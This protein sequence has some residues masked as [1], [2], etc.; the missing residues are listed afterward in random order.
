MTSAYVPITI[1]DLTQ[2][3]P[4]L[5]QLAGGM[6]TYCL[7]PESNNVNPYL[8]PPVEGTRIRFVRSSGGGNDATVRASRRATLYGSETATVSLDHI[9]DCI[10]LVAVDGDWH[11][12]N[13]MTHAA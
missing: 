3:Y 13:P 1:S 11:P 8:P 4:S 9:G 5:F 10:D 12:L 7:D 2:Y 6:R